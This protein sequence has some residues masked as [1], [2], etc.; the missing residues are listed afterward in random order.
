MKAAICLGFLSTIFAYKIW[1]LKQENHRINILNSIYNAERRIL[2]D[3]ISELEKKPTYDQ[4]FKDALIRVGGPQSDGLYR[5]G[6][7]D[8]AKLFCDASYTEG[9]HNA[10]QQFG[11]TQPKGTVKWLVPQSEKPVLTTNNDGK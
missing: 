11:Y 8:A 2:K 9:Y 4:G 7:E 3:D 10:I 1:D 5:D 6:W